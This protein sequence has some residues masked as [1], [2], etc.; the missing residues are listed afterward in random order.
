MVIQT[1][2]ELSIFIYCGHEG[3]NVV[4]DN[5]AFNFLQSQILFGDTTN[6][7]YV[8]RYKHPLHHN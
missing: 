5:I 1:D 8:Y 3:Y 4:H 7:I 6:K 2:K